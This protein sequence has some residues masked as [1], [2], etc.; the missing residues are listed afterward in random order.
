[1]RTIYSRHLLTLLPMGISMSAFAGCVDTVVHDEPSAPR[2]VV[3]H[4]QSSENVD[5]SFG[6]RDS[7]S[8]GRLLVASRP[9]AQLEA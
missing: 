7:H 3:S 8:G 9:P 4:C 2:N 1:M 5:A 6:R